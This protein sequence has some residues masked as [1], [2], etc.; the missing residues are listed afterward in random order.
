M[1]DMN[2]FL[3]VFSNVMTRSIV[4]CFWKYLKTS[5]VYFASIW[6]L[7]VY[8]FSFRVLWKSLQNFCVPGKSCYW[9]LSEALTILVVNQVC[10]S[11]IYKQPPLERPQNELV[12]VEC[13]HFYLL[14]GSIGQKWVKL[15]YA[16]TCNSK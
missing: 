2:Y 8:K 12:S 10:I 4:D 7:I 6:L 16:S 9:K 14:D 13:S 3:Q 5:S 11:F 15:L 1:K